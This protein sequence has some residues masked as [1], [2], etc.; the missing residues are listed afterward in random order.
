[1]THNAIFIIIPMYK[2]TKAMAK[3]RDKT[4]DEYDKNSREKRRID[5]LIKIFSKWSLRVFQS[6]PFN[7]AR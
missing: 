6:E 2:T 1:M 5:I 3:E 7:H 4:I